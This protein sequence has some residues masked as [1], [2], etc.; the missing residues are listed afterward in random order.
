MDLPES[1]KEV[2]KDGLDVVAVGDG[3]RDCDR[4][5][6][7]GGT[8]VRKELQRYAPARYEHEARGTIYVGTVTGCKGVQRC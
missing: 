5:D 7:S 4:A 8:Q 1:S 6:A 2:T 3:T